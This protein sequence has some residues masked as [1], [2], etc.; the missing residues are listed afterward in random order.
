[1][2]GGYAIIDLKGLS[3]DSTTY[4][5][6]PGTFKAVETAIK[7][8]KPVLIDGLKVGDDSLDSVF[9]FPDAGS[10]QINLTYNVKK[11]SN[12]MTA[13]WIE[14]NKNDTVRAK[15]G[16]V[17]SNVSP[18]NATTTTAGI[19]KQAGN[20]ADSTEATAPT[21]EEFNALLTALK[22]AGIMEADSE[23]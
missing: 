23:E 6:I 8:K 1:M 3:L 10:E 11:S 20:I 12:I 14:I 22:T 2:K 18:S 19:V 5:S 13:Y 16:Y 4:A 9:C 15:S 21:T 7:S 17:T